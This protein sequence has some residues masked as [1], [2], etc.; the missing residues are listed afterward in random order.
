VGGENTAPRD[1]HIRKT[2]T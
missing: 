2:K 1:N